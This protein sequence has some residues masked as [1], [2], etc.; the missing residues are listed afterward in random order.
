ME[1]VNDAQL[2]ELAREPVREL[3]PAA[4][5]APVVQ[6]LIVL[7]A[8]LP[9]L[10]CFWKPTLD[11]TTSRQGLL[12][13]DVL[14][15]N[16]PSDWLASSSHS[17]PD[18]RTTNLPLA[19]FLTA[20]GLKLELLS[21]ESRLLLVAYVCVS[22]MLLCLSSLAKKLGGGRLAL[23]VVILAC[24][25]PE[26]LNLCG[27]L[28]PLGLPLALGILALRGVCSRAGAGSHWLSWS[29]VGNGL[30]LAAGWLAGG[31]LAIGIWSVLLVASMFAWFHPVESVAAATWSRMI[32]ARLLQMAVAFL[33]LFG[34][35]IVALSFV[36]AWLLIFQRNVRV[37]DFEWPVGWWERVWPA[38]S[39]SAMASRALLEMCGAWLGFVLLGALRLARGRSVARDG[40]EVQGTWFLVAWL[41]VG[42]LCWWVTWPDHHGEF[43]E[44]SAWPAFVLLPLLCLAAWGCEAILRREFGVGSVVAATS[45]T[46][47]VQWAPYWSASTLSAGAT[48]GMMIAALFAVLVTVLLLLVKIAQRGLSE[49][50]R[51]GVLR[52]CVV[53][54][55]AWNVAAGV[56]TRR[57]QSDDERELLAFRR[58]LLLEPTPQQCWLL[59]TEP[60]PARLKFF[61]RC[62]WPRVALREADRWES[63]QPPSS[64]AAHAAAAN[65]PA[66]GRQ[67]QRVLVVTWGTNLRFPFEDSKRRGQQL[68][69]VTVPHYFQGRPIKGYRWSS[70]SELARS[71]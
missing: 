36:A 22:A 1:V 46:L 52:T 10:V 11:E 6:P 28:P 4:R 9:G 19:T 24:S 35:T 33:H 14:D 65:D 5:R 68:S 54:L 66:D 39:R 60:V 61:L 7:L 26:I 3:F 40:A 56:F 17:R 18:L 20:L 13:V 37:P 16:R 2:L 8:I 53:L 51:R 41:L 47:A 12:A 59:T 58:H 70:R 15:S 34:V 25:H 32:H 63:I 48:S 49:R 71:P 38:E 67:T 64:P 55:I 62:L 42:C 27:R 23:I 44:S 30:A 29:F 45:V 21:P 50:S 31:E 57:E 69:Q 43:R